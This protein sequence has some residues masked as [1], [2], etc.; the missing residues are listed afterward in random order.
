M[1]F[2]EGITAMACFSE[3]RFSVFRAW[4]ASL[5]CVRIGFRLWQPNPYIPLHI[6]VS[7]FIVE[8]LATLAR[9]AGFKKNV[10]DLR[11]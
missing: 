8:S 3:E 6:R 10:E 1:E 4:L 9:K 11:E 5:Q 7:N 2:I